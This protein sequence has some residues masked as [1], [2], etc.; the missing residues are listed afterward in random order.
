[1]YQKRCH[2]IAKKLLYKLGIQGRLAGP[3][4]AKLL[5]KITV[6]VVCR[7]GQNPGVVPGWL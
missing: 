3:S 6:Q 5:K 7:Y 1:M 4:K 2:S